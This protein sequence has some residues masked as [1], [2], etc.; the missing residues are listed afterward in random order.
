LTYQ[1]L[2]LGEFGKRQNPETGKW[3]ERKLSFEEYLSTAEARDKIVKNLARARIA[4]ELR[5]RRYRFGTQERWNITMVER[6]VEA[7]ETLEAMEMDPENPGQERPTG[8]TFFTHEDMEWIREHSNT[9][10]SRMLREDLIY[11][12]LPLGLL[13]GSWD[14]LK[15]IF[16]SAFK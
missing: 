12:A 14:L 6:F 7:L 1:V 3:E 15:I 11:K 4:G 10:L 9:N 5:D 13:G 8:K 2:F 16:G